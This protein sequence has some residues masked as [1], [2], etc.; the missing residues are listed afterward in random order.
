MFSRAGVALDVRRS[1]GRIDV[2]YLDNVQGPVG[3][4][5]GEMSIRDFTASTPGLDVLVS[6][7]L[8]FTGVTKG[9]GGPT[10]I[11][12]GSNVATLADELAHGLGNVTTVKIPLVSNTFT[13]LLFDLNEFYVSQG[14]DLTGRMERN[15]REA[16]ESLAC[17]GGPDCPK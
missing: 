1:E 6:G 16:A 5:D 2:S 12:T 8:G 14:W 17:P 9:I 15:I 11:G 3:T 13:D 7:G 10:M 4:P